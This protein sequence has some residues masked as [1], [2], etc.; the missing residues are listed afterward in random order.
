MAMQSGSETLCL[1]SMPDS[2]I[3]RARYCSQ[4]GQAVTVSDAT[5]CKEC[6]AP[7]AGTFWLKHEITWRPFTAFILS[8]IPGLGHFYKRQPVRGM[9]WFGFVM[10]MY[11]VIPPLGFMFH[12]ICAGNAALSGAI[13]EEAL[14][15]SARGNGPR[16][17]SA[18]PGPR[19]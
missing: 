9:L 18:T 7:L 12:A 5:F 15:R 19:S 11:A 4:C 3:E 13:R 2:T 8:V 14:T 16:Q 10:F 6:G 17:F 1:L